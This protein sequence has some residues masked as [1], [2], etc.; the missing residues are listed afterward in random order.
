MSSGFYY[1][2]KAAIRGWERISEFDTS[3]DFKNIKLA[4]PDNWLDIMKVVNELKNRKS[5]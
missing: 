4:N 2:I 5:E 1:L 3:E